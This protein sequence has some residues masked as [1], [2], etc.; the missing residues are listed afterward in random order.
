MPQINL[1]DFERTLDSRP[2][3]WK[4]TPQLVNGPDLVEEQAKKLADRQVLEGEIVKNG[5]NLPELTDIPQKTLP[6]G[7]LRRIN[8]RNIANLA[9]L[10][11]QLTQALPLN[12][13]GLPDYIYRSDLL[14]FQAFRQLEKPVNELHDDTI[15]DLQSQLAAAIYPLTYDDGYPL[16]PQGFPLWD[17]MPHEPKEA[18]AAFI[19]YLE[20]AGVRQ[21]SKLTS[22]PLDDVAEWNTL[23]F[24]SIRVKAYDL[25]RVA[26]HERQKIVRLL[27]TEDDHFAMASQLMEE[28]KKYFS[29]TP[30]IDAE[31]KVADG[32]DYKEVIS[33]MEKLVK[34]QRIS[35][36]LPM[37][38]NAIA[39]DGDITRTMVPTEVIMR[40]ITEKQG[41]SKENKMVDDF[42]ILK[43]DPEG[44]DM[45]QE[46]IVRY[47]NQTLGK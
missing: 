6:F 36:G 26:H 17:I 22:Y 20:F 42:D 41:G 45:A 21:I 31:G 44:V 33:V 7:P 29:Q 14:N 13:Y 19:E 9:D 15:S 18:H 38:S 37:Q 46:L 8:A 40:Q 25:Y 43:E 11:R 24:W 32:M 5:A 35:V 30:L 3:G 12:N 28:C 16:T 23:Y 4:G 34:I 39:K 1:Q 27:N 2:G 47:Q 10:V